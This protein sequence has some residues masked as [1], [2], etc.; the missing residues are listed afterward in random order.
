MTFGKTYRDKI[1]GFQGVCTGEAG[2]ISGCSQA[3]ISA[4]M[5]K[6]LTIKAEWFD[7]QRLE[8]IEKIK[9]IYLKN[10]ET[11][12]HDIPAPIR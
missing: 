10:D 9:V 8:P 11:P 12:G 6:S 7:V 3:L 2:Y 4:K 1:T 5:D